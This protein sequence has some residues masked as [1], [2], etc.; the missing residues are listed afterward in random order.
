[1]GDSRDRLFATRTELSN[2][3]NIIL[4]LQDSRLIVIHIKIIGRRE[5]RHHTWESSSLCL[6]IHAVT[7]VL[8]L[9]CSNDRQKIVFFQEGASSGIGKEIRTSSDMVVYEEV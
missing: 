8:G 4:V 1:M 5:N 9:V 2:V 3:H 6:P 7:S